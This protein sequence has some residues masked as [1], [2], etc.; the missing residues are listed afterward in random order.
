[1]ELKE[2]EEHLLFAF[3]VFM[4][5]AIAIPLVLK[6]VYP[7]LL[8]FGPGRSVMLVV[9]AILLAAFAYSTLPSSVLLIIAIIFL[10]Y[11]TINDALTIIRDKNNKGA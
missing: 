5:L 3:F 8:E 2:L 11:I 6:R 1:M 9:S 4:Y 7:I 10:I